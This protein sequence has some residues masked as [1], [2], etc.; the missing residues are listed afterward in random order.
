MRIHRDNISNFPRFSFCTEPMFT[1][2]T[3]FIAI[4]KEHSHF[5]L[6]F[7]NSAIGRYVLK[8]TVSILDDGGYLLQKVF[9]ETILL[10]T[11][12][13][14]MMKPIE[15]L[16]SESLDNENPKIRK[17]IDYLFYQLFSFSDDE[18]RFIEDDNS[19]LLVRR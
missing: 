8:R 18:I 11:C 5:I 7:M 1:D 12:N 14:K 15:N 9:L 3:C 10:P 13:A 17:E 19:K 16:V 2:K 6:G 4:A